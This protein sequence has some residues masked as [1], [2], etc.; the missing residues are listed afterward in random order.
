MFRERPVL[1]FQFDVTKLQ[2]QLQKVMQIHL[3]QSANFGPLPIN[4]CMTTNH[5][6]TR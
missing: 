1:T 5:I 4:A 6:I 2:K 3:D